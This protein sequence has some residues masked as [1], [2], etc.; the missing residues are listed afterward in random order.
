MLVITVE[1]E[2]DRRVPLGEVS[3]LVLAGPVG[4][5]NTR[6]ARGGATPNSHCLDE[7]RLLVPHQS[8]GHGPRSAAARRAQY[9][10]A[11]DPARALR[12]ARELV[13]AKIR[14]QRTFLRRNW[15]GETDPREAVME[16]LRHLAEKAMHVPDRAGLLGIE[17]EAAALYFQ[18]FPALFTETTAGARHIRLCAPLSPAARGPDE[19]VPLALLRTADPDLGQRM[20]IAGLDPWVGL[21]HVAQP[22]RPSLA[23]DMMEPFRP[24]LAD[25]AVLMA[26]NNGE[27]GADAFI[28]SGGGCALTPGGRRAL[29][30]AWERRLDQELSHPVFGYQVS[31]RR[32]L[33]VQARLLARHLMGEIAAYPHY[34]PR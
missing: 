2:T 30:A 32:M 25:S 9:E 1:G 15:R 7:F 17:G 21:Y 27:V 3:E 29:I 31:M 6:P 28:R 5:Y 26:V 14:N 12:F 13:G 24:I 20:E 23:L 11:G 10:A 34:I 16:R 22:G 4:L 8:G 18:A 33:H 19:C